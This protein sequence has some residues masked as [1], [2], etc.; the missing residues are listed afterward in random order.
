MTRRDEAQVHECS[1]NVRSSRSSSD[2]E[3][4]RKRVPTE[5]PQE[6][7]VS[8]ID[9]FSLLGEPGARQSLHDG[10]LSR[11]NDD[12]GTTVAFGS[13]LYRPDRIGT[14]FAKGR[15]PCTIHRLEQVNYTHTRTDFASEKHRLLVVRRG[16][17][18][19]G[20][21]FMG[22]SCSTS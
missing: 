13:P 1:T 15:R 17:A 4:S 21:C 18:C 22:K 8:R 9:P 16:Q 2:Q 6:I 12:G 11:D 7:E 20:C 3:A 5:I 19:G 14:N 10:G